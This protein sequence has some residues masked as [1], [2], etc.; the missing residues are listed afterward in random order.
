MEAERYQSAVT[1]VDTLKCHTSPERDTTQTPT[2]PY[3]QLPS[4]H[5]IH[6]N[7]WFELFI[8]VLESLLNDKSG[9]TVKLSTKY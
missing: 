5:R 8:V 6:A 7:R 9:L 3:T 1:D 4:L 2:V